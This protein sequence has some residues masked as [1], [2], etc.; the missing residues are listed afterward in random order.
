M[1]CPQGTAVDD[2]PRTGRIS[3]NRERP[4]LD[5]MGGGVI[6][7]SCGGFRTD[8]LRLVDSPG[9]STMKK[10][11]LLGKDNDMARSVS[12]HDADHDNAD[13]V[14][15]DWRRR[16][17]DNL[18][19]GLLTYTGLQIFVTMKQLK[20]VSNSMLPYLALV[21]LVGAIIPAARM[22]ERHWDRLDDVEALDPVHA[23]RFRRDRMIIWLSAIGLPFLLA[24]LARGFAMMGG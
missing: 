9:T 19:Y 23:C 11:A 16:I 22:L 6:Y 18:A 21:V 2:R 10:V 13:H 1:A 5:P 3:R 20:E 14:A 7:F 8:R 17:S 15:K 12:R 24:G 4:G